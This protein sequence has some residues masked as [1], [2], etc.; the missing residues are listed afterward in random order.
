[1]P[2]MTIKNIPDNLY[3]KLKDAAQIHHRSLN[4]EIIYCLEAVLTPCKMTTAE[5]LQRAR[6]L[7]P[8]IPVGAV[9]PADI[10]YAINQGRP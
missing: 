4:S 10:D 2:A 5:R 1:M 6:S 9:A 8:Q 7:R 3:Q